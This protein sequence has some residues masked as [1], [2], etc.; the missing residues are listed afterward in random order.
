LGIYILFV[1]VVVICAKEEVGRIRERNSSVEE[2]GIVL[3]HPQDGL[4]I[5]LDRISDMHR[6]YIC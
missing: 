6:K 1:E 2:N 5:C 4:D 3:E